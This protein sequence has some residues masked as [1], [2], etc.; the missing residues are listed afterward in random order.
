[1]AGFCYSHAPSG[2]CN[3]TVICAVHPCEL[4]IQWQAVMQTVRS[5][6]AA[7]IGVLASPTLVSCASPRTTYLA[8]G[9]RGYS[10]SCHGFLNSWN[11]CLVKAGRICGTRGYEIIDEEPYDRTL[12][13]GCK[14]PVTA[15]K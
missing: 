4:A 9:P 5:W 13:F 12:M 11:S 2:S 15:A 6:S 7:V 14:S 10:V 3:E 1:M 8:D